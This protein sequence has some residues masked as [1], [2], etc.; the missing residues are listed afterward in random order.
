MSQKGKLAPPSS[1]KSGKHSSRNP[2]RYVRR[3][4][5]HIK[6]I[7]KDPINYPNVAESVLLPQDLFVSRP[8]YLVMEGHSTINR[9]AVIMNSRAKV[10]IKHHF[11]AG[12][13]LTIIT[14]DHMPIIGRFLNTVTNEDKDRLDINHEYDKEVIIEEDVWVGIG[15][16]I[17]KGVT[18]GRGAIIAAGSIVTKS[19]PPYCVAA[20]IPAKPI[21][22]RLSIDEIKIHEQELYQESDYTDLNVLQEIERSISRN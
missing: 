1:D 20:G 22:M 14:G 2:L 9:G 13:K 6:A 15:V 12:P 8:D 17:L 19:I 16:T 21:K 7:V 3:L 5:G 4:L 10:I 11:V 18:I